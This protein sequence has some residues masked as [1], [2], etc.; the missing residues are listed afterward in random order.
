MREEPVRT[1]MA[2]VVIVGVFFAV[3]VVPV[4]LLQTDNC[5]LEN[6]LWKQRNVYIRS[7]R[8]MI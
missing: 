7:F 2:L 8:Q 5:Q 6:S 3:G 1:G 4:N